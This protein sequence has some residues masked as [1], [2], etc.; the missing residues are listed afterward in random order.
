MKLIYNRIFL[1]YFSGTGNA[2]AAAYWFAEVAR[3]KKIDCEVMQLYRKT[4]VKQPASFGEN[5]LIGFFF[6]THGLNAAPAILNFIWHF[7]S[8]TNASVFVVNTRAGMKVSRL[9]LPGLSGL[10]Q[11]LPA[12]MLRLKG[13]KF[14]GMQPIDLPSNWISL[15]PGLKEKVV[16]SIFNRCERITKQFANR[17]LNGGTK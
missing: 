8:I 1:Y 4:V 7:P 10:A 3:T 17:I 16:E 6:P 11:L 9:F 12:A 15:H 2:R 13:F 5:H 14:V